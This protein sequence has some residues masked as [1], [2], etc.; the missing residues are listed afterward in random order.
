MTIA[1][2]CGIRAPCQTFQDHDGRPH[3]AR[4]APCQQ[5]IARSSKID[6]RSSQPDWPLLRLDWPSIAPVPHLPSSHSHRSGASPRSKQARNCCSRIHASYPV[7]FPNNPVP[8]LRLRRT[9]AE[10]LRLNNETLVQ[11]LVGPT[12][13]VTSELVQSVPVWRRVV[14]CRIRIGSGSMALSAFCCW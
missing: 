3:E 2:M 7:S 14:S 1:R 11:S 4:L 9:Q 8:A 13:I 10:A 6:W 5:P 12:L